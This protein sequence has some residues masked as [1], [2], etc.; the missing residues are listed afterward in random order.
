MA[1]RRQIREAFYSELETAA[2]PYV[3]AANISQ[4]YPNTPEDLP[5]VVHNDQY[6]DVPLNREAAPVTVETDDTGNTTAHIYVELMEAQFALLIASDSEQE[7][8]DAY[9][10][11][12]TYFGGYERPV[13]DEADIHG[14]VEDV[15]VRDSTSNDSENRDP[16]SR[17]DRLNVMVEFQRFYTKDTTPIEEVEQN[18]DADGDGVTDITRTTTTS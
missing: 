1:T 17:G 4:E 15:D 14:D 2:D 11:V 13:K 18:I 6:R 12:R 8:E 16:P 7:K 3:P 5:A 10:A 9:E